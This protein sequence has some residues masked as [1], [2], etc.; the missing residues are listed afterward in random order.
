MAL[1][2]DWVAD[3]RAGSSRKEG[4]R[5]R[6]NAPGGEE[7]AVRSA[8]VCQAYCC[9]QHVKKIRIGRSGDA[10]ERESHSYYNNEHH[11]LRLSHSVY[12]ASP[13]N[14][15]Y[16]INICHRP[17]SI[18]SHVFRQVEV[19]KVVQI[20]YL[21]YFSVKRASRSAA[22]SKTCWFFTISTNFLRP[23]GLPIMRTPTSFFSRKNNLR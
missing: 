1:Y 9:Q 16:V 15:S 14:L 7:S 3:Y 13:Q 17:E 22:V 18:L 10:R 21:C 11:L 19:L 20:A 2:L 5:G 8:Q 12:R 6:N 4:H 23:L